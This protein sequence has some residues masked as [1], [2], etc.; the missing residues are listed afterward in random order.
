MDVDDARAV[1]VCAHLALHIPGRTDAHL[2]TPTAA[3]T[4]TDQGGKRLC[5]LCFFYLVNSGRWI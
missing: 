5:L 4:P 1:Q 3:T 2:G